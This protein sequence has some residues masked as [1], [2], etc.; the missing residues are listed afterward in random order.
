[1]RLVDKRRL[2]P[3]ASSTA[4]YHLLPD[5]RTDKKA[6]AHSCRVQDDSQN[7]PDSSREGVARLIDGDLTVN[8]PESSPPRD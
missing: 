7:E 8:L 4:N 5:E 2:Q 3:T 1:M 6:E